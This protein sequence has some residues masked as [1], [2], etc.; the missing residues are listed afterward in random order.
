MF[1]N[2]FFWRA[3]VSYFINSTLLK[4]R[5]ERETIPHNV[6]EEISSSWTSHSRILHRALSL[7]PSYSLIDRH[8]MSCSRGRRCRQLFLP[9]AACI[10][11]SSEAVISL[12]LA[13]KTASGNSIQ[14]S[15]TFCLLHKLSS[16]VFFAG[17]CRFRPSYFCTPA[18][19]DQSTILFDLFRMFYED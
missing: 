15:L 2:F 19:G 6:C 9:T 11:S 14:I 12:Q 17:H 5:N 7:S 4:H 10:T 3:E 16:L 18:S 13:M 1:F 8:S